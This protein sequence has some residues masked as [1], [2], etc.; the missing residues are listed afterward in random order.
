MGCCQSRS[1]PSVESA[2]VPVA[3]LAPAR[4][5]DGPW[6]IVD[7]ASHKKCDD[8]G[9]HVHVAFKKCDKKDNNDV[10]KRK[11]YRNPHGTSSK[12]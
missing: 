9:E 10:T 1:R 12:H 6:L 2:A 11:C 8:D 4:D 7:D 5:D 3:A